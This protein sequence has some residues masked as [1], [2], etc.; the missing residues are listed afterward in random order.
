MTTDGAKFEESK[1]EQ[2]FG[3]R[4]TTRRMAQKL[5]QRIKYRRVY[6]VVKFQNGKKMDRYVGRGEEELQK[7]HRGAE[8]DFWKQK[9]EFVLEQGS[10]KI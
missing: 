7:E 1:R 5:C 3:R 10:N 8:R 2:K 4:K 9:A 6:S